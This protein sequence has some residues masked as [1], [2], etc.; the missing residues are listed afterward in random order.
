L[1]D[2]EP[3]KIYIRQSVAYTLSFYV[4]LLLAMLLGRG[5]EGLL[6][7]AIHTLIVCGFLFSMFFMPFCYSYKIAD[8]DRGGNKW[9]WLQ[10]VHIACVLP[11]WFGYFKMEAHSVAERGEDVGLTATTLFLI[12]SSVTF[13][14]LLGFLFARI[15]ANFGK[16]AALKTQKPA[17]SSKKRR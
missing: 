2:N 5:A 8:A 10:L 3:H 11:V 14:P 12:A 13:A 7:S 4:L 15:T 16:S 6:Q 1:K 17:K 9:L